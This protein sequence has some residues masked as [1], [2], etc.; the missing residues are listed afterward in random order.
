MWAKNMNS[1]QTAPK[2]AVWSGYILFVKLDTKDGKIDNI[3]CEWQEKGKN[4]YGIY[5]NS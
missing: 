1:D 3:S 5:S 4:K 2:G